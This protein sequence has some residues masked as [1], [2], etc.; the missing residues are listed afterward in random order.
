MITFNFKQ[1]K[2]S[3]KELGLI[4]LFRLEQEIYKE[5]GKRAN[6]LKSLKELKRGYKE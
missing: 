4:E 2:S 1:I 6:K 5:L 3:L